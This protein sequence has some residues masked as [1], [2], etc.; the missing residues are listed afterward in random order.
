MMELLIRTLAKKFLAFTHTKIFADIIPTTNWAYSVVKSE[1][2]FPKVF[3]TL[4]RPKSMLLMD[5]KIVEAHRKDI[6]NE[7]LNAIKK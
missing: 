5:G 3:E 1:Q 4:Y 2:Y 7:W 6:V